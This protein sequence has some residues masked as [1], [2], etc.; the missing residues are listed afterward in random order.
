MADETSREIVEVAVF[1]GD[2]LLRVEYV[3]RSAAPVFAD[4]CIPSAEPVALPRG[5][6]GSQAE[7]R[8]GDFAARATVVHAGKRAARRRPELRPLLIALGV[9][10]LHLAWFVAAAQQPRDPPREDMQLLRSYLSS[11]V[12][13][14][15][16]GAAD[17]SAKTEDD[18]P[19]T[20][21]SESGPPRAHRTVSE[22]PASDAITIDE[23]RS[24]G[25]ISLL[26]P[27][28]DSTAEF[29]PDGP[30]G[31]LFGD[32]VGD[33]HGAAGLSLS[34]TGSGGGGSGAGVPSNGIHTT[35]CFAS[36]GTLAAHHTSMCHLPIVVPTVIGRLPPETI[37][38]VVRASVGRFRACYEDGLARNPKLSGR[39]ATKFMIGRDGSVSAVAD[40]GSDLPDENVRACI[41]RAF[42]SLDFP[43][44]PGA[45]VSV[46][47]PLDLSPE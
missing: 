35:G 28:G 29:A 19:V 44:A 42:A 15:P 36:R 7:T 20:S 38:R 1:W 31:S 46:V 8:A 23:A 4:W 21:T 33:A 16:R 18:A 6:V 37:Q 43:A 14:F 32:L 25:V 45:V 12:P 24:F 27:A 41:R 22:S 47:Y 10:A 26:G 13:T 5:P 17:D 40:D 39:V 2:E 11:T 9:A 30:P 34:G 3:P